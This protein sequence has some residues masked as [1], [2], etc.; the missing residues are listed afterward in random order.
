MSTLDPVQQ[1]LKNLFQRVNNG[2]LTGERRRTNTPKVA[3]WPKLLGTKS[4]QALVD[5]CMGMKFSDRGGKYSSFSP[6]SIGRL[7]LAASRAATSGSRRISWGF[8]IN[9]RGRI[10]LYS[11][12]VV[13]GHEYEVEKPMISWVKIH[14]ILLSERRR[15]S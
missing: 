2:S 7:S 1:V 4:V 6:F 12:L 3:R 13:R 15:L 11:A 9:T 14:W 10:S 8:R 5:G